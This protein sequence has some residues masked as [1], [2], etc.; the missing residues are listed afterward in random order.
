MGSTPDERALRAIP[1]IRTKLTELRALASESVAN[2][3]FSQDDHFAF[4]GVLFHAKQLEHAD[5]VLRLGD[6]PDASLIARS[7]MEGLW[8]LKWA[9]QAP[10]ERAE[11]WRAFSIIYDWRILQEKIATNSPELTDERKRRIEGRLDEVHDTFITRSALK[12]AG[13]GE[14]P[15]S[16]PYQRTWSGQT[17]RSLAEATGGIALYTGPYS[18]FSDRHHW[19]PAGLGYGIQQDG[20]KLFYDGKAP[21]TEATALS[22]AF[23]CLWECSIVLAEHLGTGYDDRLMDLADVYTREHKQREELHEHATAPGAG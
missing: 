21:S 19:S 1:A 22:V 7:M 4:M 6:H 15:P 9:A 14:A 2:V 16:D 5:G 12:L 17:A 13:K 18:T 20:T 3:R 10:S 8:Q 11:Q 23:E